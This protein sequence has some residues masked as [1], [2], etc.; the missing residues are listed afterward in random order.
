MRCY[1]VRRICSYQSQREQGTEYSTAFNLIHIT[2]EHGSVFVIGCGAG[3]PLFRQAEA[4]PEKERQARRSRTHEYSEEEEDDPPSLTRLCLLSL[5][6]NMKDVWTQDYSQNYMDQ[7]FFRYVMGPFSLLPNELLE[8]LLCVLSHRNLL[9]RPAL[10][11]LLL[12]QLHR[13]SLQH[14]CNLVTANLCSLIAARCQAL[15]SLNLSGALNVSATALSSLLGSLPL[16]QSLTLAGTL[17][18]RGV[19]A[20]VAQRCPLLKHLDVSRCVHLRPSALLPLAQCSSSCSLARLLALDIGLEEN[21]DDG[22]ASAAFLLL[23]LPGLQ[24]VALDNVG[25]ACVL[26]WKQDFGMTDRFTKK[27]GVSSL[28]EMWTRR[29]ESE[30]GTAKMMDLEDKMDKLL[31]VDESKADVDTRT[32]V[33]N[34]EKTLK[35]SL[36]DV[37]S[38]SL[39]SLSAFGQLCPDL[40]S[41]TLNCHDEEEDEGAAFWWTTPLTRGLS[42]WSGQLRRLSLQFP[43]PLSEL[44]PSLQAAGSSL[45]SLTLQGVKAD[46]H[47]FFLELIHACPKLT[48]LS[49]HIDPPRSNQEEEDEDEDLEDWDLPCLPH[50]SSLTL[51]FTLD[52]RQVKPVLCWGSLRGPLWAL[53]RGAPQLQTLSLIATPCRLDPVFRLVLDHHAKPLGGSDQL[54]LRSLRHVSLKR[55][56]V[57]MQTAVRLLNVC[58]RLSDLDLSGCWSMTL[59]NI[60]KLQSKASRRRHRLQITWT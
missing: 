38:I 59:S 33:E 53:L 21:E 49:I 32:D 58:H 14:S 23:G 55:S 54:P 7:Y 1:Q 4:R 43:G 41:L 45:T 50:L 11:L 17:S 22:T 36:L 31:H 9:S 27:K 37:Q 24:Q 8:E 44:I 60:T 29:V 51:N 34:Q 10:H 18:D 15:K 57:T 35:L 40:C 19:I 30:K 28:Q 20:T 12:P 6:E 39:N 56:D 25:Q 5:A 46:G 42:T 48:T 3:M 47:L 52:E 26:L 2:E 13:L 16:L